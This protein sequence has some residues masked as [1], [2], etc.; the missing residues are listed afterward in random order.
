MCIASSRWESA[1]RRLALPA[2]QEGH[3]CAAVVQEVAVGA[4]LAVVFSRIWFVDLE[5]DARV[6]CLGV[7]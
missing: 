2:E 1:W 6:V 4:S 7:S 5:Y 3:G